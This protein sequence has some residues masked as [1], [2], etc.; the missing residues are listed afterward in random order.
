MREEESEILAED[1]KVGEEFITT[2]NTLL[3]R[4]AETSSERTSSRRARIEV[5]ESTV[6]GF[7]HISNAAY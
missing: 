6:L 7:A 5:I 2:G 4:A 1:Y 3:L